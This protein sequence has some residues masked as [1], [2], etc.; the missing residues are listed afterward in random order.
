MNTSVKPRL[1]DS[2]DVAA[3]KALAAQAPAPL[4]RVLRQAAASRDFIAGRL[5]QGPRISPKPR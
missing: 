3:R 2:R 5:P 1:P 4:A